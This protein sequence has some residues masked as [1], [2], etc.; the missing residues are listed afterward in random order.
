MDQQRPDLYE[1][2][3]R[4]LHVATSVS[5]IDGSASQV[6]VWG[7]AETTEF[8]TNDARMIQQLASVFEQFDIHTEVW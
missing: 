4:F 3:S 5:D 6:I 8:Y 7:E 1:P 2:S